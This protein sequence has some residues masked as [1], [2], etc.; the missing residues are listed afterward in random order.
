MDIIIEYFSFPFVRYA[1]IVGVLTS[2]CA[3][4]LGVTL[5]LRRFSFIG[6]GLSHVAF[7]ALALAGVLRLSN[8]TPLVMTVTVICAV[9]IMRAGR[10]SAIGGDS[11]V[12]M[13]SVGAMAI[14]YLLLNIF[15]SSGNISG[16]VC[17]A[18]FGSTKLIT[19]KLSDVIL[20]AAVSLSTVILFILFYNKLFAATFDEDFSYVCGMKTDIFNLATAVCAAA[21]IVMAMN[22]VG[23]LLVSALIVFPALCAMRIFNSFLQVTLFSAAVSVFCST[24]GMLIAVGA[25][26]PVGATIVAVN[27]AVFI[28]C[29]I[30]GKKVRT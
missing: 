30:V 16:D 6:D 20:C 10:H 19:L 12:A 7:G 4:L 3:S 15:P 27:I 5:V 9:L 21:I 2:L 24:A 18:L 14:G 28:V 1:F 13:L 22:L 8:S 23:S 26:T 29:G 17:S 11:A 25:G